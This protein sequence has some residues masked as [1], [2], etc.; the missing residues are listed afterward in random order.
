MAQQPLEDGLCT[1][2][3]IHP[4]KKRGHQFLL[5]YDQLAGASPERS[6]LRPGLPASRTTR[7][8]S[9][10]PS[11]AARPILRGRWSSTAARALSR[12]PTMAATTG[13]H[14]TRRERT[15]GR[16][17]FPTTSTSTQSASANLAIRSATLRGRTCSTMASSCGL[18]LARQAAVHL[19]LLVGSRVF[20]LALWE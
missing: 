13:A 4:D 11:P 20:F 1:S 12:N 18:V 2:T 7:K 14:H 9:T 3:Q 8:L 15:S 5:F 10:A 19:L 6:A 16:R 17:A